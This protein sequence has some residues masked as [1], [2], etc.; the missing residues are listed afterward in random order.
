MYL[1][2]RVNMSFLSIC[3]KVYFALRILV[4]SP[5]ENFT[6][7]RPVDAELFHADRLYVSFVISLLKCVRIAIRINLLQKQ[8]NHWA[9][10]GICGL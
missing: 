3:A 4:N 7:T 10:R 2:L 8:Y 1:G 9:V 6:K 5:L